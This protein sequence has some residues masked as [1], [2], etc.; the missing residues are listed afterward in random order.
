MLSGSGMRRRDAGVSHHIIENSLRNEFAG[1]KTFA[2]LAWLLECT[3]SPFLQL[4]GKLKKN[5][6]WYP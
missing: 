6:L 4:Y 3:H 1:I 5:N 2:E